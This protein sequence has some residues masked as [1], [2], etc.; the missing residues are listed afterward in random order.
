MKQKLAAL[1]ALI[2]IV[3][4]AACA[5]APAV[6]PED[7][8]Q[9]PAVQE[10]PVTEETPAESPAKVLEPETQPEA[11]A[12]GAEENGFDVDFTDTPQRVQADIEE[13]V[14]YD[15]SVP[16]LTLANSEAADYINEGFSKLSSQLVSYAQETV[17]HTAQEKV[18]IGFLEAH[19]DVRAE[20][21]KILV[22]YTVHERYASDDAVTET[23]TCYAFDAATGERIP[24]E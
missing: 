2:F 5:K 13:I 8:Q 18:T 20:D 9:T 24:T 15:I 22:D 23:V 11:Q 10:Q 7:T 12:P 14:S 19:Y 4:M 3:T 17:Y 1:L 6:T 16:Q 21:G